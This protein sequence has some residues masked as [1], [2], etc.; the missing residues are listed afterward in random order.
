MAVIK[1]PSTTRETETQQV[2]EFAPGGNMP[3]H[4]NITHDDFP[5]SPG[6]KIKH[7]VPDSAS[8]SEQLLEATNF[9]KHAIP[10]IAIPDISAAA[11]AIYFGEKC[12]LRILLP[13]ST[14]TTTSLEEDRRQHQRRH[15]KEEDEDSD[16]TVGYY[17]S[18]DFL[19]RNWTQSIHMIPPMGF[20][21]FATGMALCHP[22][23][24]VAGALTAFGTATVVGAGYDFY[25]TPDKKWNKMFCNDYYGDPGEQVINNNNN[26]GNTQEHE[27]SEITFVLTEDDTTSGSAAAALDNTIIVPLTESLSADSLLLLQQPQTRVESPT[28]TSLDIF[29]VTQPTETEWVQKYYPPLANMAAENVEFHGLNALEFFDVFFGNNAP[30]SYQEF[31]KKRQDKHIQ[32]GLW[33]PLE[34][35]AQPSLHHKAAVRS[36]GDEASLGQVSLQERILKFHTKTNSYF[37]PPWAPTTKVQRSLQASKRLLVLES[38][39]TVTDIPFSDRFCVMERWIVTAKKQSGRYVSTLSIYSEAFFIK[40]CPFESKIKSASKQTILDIANQWT[41]MAQDALKLTEEHRLQR[42]QKGRSGLCTVTTVDSLEQVVPKENRAPK[43]VFT[44]PK[45]SSKN[46]GDCIEVRHLG[47]IKSWVVIDDEPEAGAPSLISNKAEQQQQQ[48]QHV[49]LS[50]PSGVSNSR[51]RLYGMDKMGRSLSNAMAG[52]RKR[53]SSI[54]KLRIAAMTTRRHTSSEAEDSLSRP[55]V[56]L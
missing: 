53:V 50:P 35:V 56:D 1:V 20:A 47:E 17:D 24:F 43:I 48:Q 46:V 52:S 16:S 29:R 15:E 40:S 2:E 5:L 28:K 26:S 7:V 11:A 45:E 34:R 9:S 13:V 37:A 32:Y 39:T 6:A 19:K 4:C 27:V 14:S 22:L 38:K 51:Q 21:A 54:G 33:E 18:S 41:G 10:D 12:D 3:N 31:Q 49:V 42:I 25:L 55:C 36:G 23:L 30:Y 8:F 44:T